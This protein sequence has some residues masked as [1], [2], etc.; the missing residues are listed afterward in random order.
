MTTIELDRIAEDYILSNNA[1]PAFKGY[2]QAGSY[3]YP[4]SICASIDD[5]V[6]HGIPGN[7]CS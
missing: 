2:S 3:D 1:N 5:E 6:V 7:Q 4:G